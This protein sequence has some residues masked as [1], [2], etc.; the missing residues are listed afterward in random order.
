MKQK[1]I[2]RW[3][4]ALLA[5]ALTCT[6]F[7]GCAALTKESAADIEGVKDYVA[8]AEDTKGTLKVLVNNT[9]K[10]AP[11]AAKRAFKAKYP[12]VQ[13]EFVT[14]DIRLDDSSE[15][16]KLF[17]RQMT[18]DGADIV[19]MDCYS[20]QQICDID[21]V[22]QAGAY[23]DLNQYFYKDPDWSWDGY[24]KAV[25]DGMM[26][27]NKLYCLPLYYELPVLVTTDKL[28]EQ[29]GINLKKCDTGIGLMEELT[30]CAER[31]KESESGWSV[32]SAN[33]P[34]RFHELFNVDPVTFG[35]D[36][37]TVRFTKDFEKT[38]VAYDALG[39]QLDWFEDWTEERK[40]QFGNAWGQMYY[41]QLAADHC[42]FV[43]S[44]YFNP[45]FNGLYS[46]A[47][48]GKLPVM[49][50][51]YTADG[52]GISAQATLTASIATGCKNPELAY[53]FVKCLLSE[54]AQAKFKVT[55]NDGSGNGN[56][57]DIPL[58][59]SVIATTVESANAG[60]M[61]N[62]KVEDVA[63]NEVTI[64]ASEYIEQFIELSEQVVHTYMFLATEYM[65]EM[66]F[67]G[68]SQY[69]MPY[70]KRVKSLEN[71]YDD[72]E[73]QLEIYATE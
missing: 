66:Y 56:G 57:F 40:I 63:G 25:V 9:D 15:L 8:P 4:A 68:A 61:V 72:A 14:Y 24:S 36:K 64:N 51:V 55:G 50:P 31:E 49:V 58:K 54:D 52:S 22:Q 38:L 18:G 30:K 1:H 46:I 23:I 26:Q 2:S 20:F 73:T 45:L 37:A 11:E 39:Q 27:G 3:I 42:Y 44:D 21:K 12:K 32:L 35:S 29:S 41:I 16:E 7:T 59:Q 48:M 43:Y 65:G 47:S 6:A 5:G 17:T 34:Q 28:L 62:L 53:E 70:F 10:T 71:C 19:L 67:E 13:V 69:F 33:Y 60:Q